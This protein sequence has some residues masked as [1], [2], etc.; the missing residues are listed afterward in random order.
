MAHLLVSL[1]D[2]LPEWHGFEGVDGRAFVDLLGGVG[3]ADVHSVEF[4]DE[5]LKGGH[6]LVSTSTLGARFGAV[7]VNGARSETFALS[8]RIT[9]Q[10]PDDGR[11]APN[12]LLF[13]VVARATQVFG[14]QL[15]AHFCRSWSGI[16]V[17][18]YTM[19]GD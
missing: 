3:D 14:E 13:A 15:V 8:P 5:K 2:C 10:A 11:W 9:S 17:S 12:E 18:D 19:V 1:Q 6:V 7:F 16:K 4:E